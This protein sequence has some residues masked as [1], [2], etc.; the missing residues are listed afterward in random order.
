MYG[1]ERLCFHLKWTL[2]AYA[3]QSKTKV[4]LKQD[5]LLGN[6]YFISLF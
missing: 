3:C 6:V 2:L 4:I 1:S 5:N